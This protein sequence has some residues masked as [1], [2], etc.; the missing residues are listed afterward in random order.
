MN[1]ITSVLFFI[2]VGGIVVVVVSVLFTEG[3]TR[4]FATGTLYL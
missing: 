2:S 3:E 1:I 4:K